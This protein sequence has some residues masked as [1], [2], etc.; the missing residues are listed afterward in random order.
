MKSDRIRKWT[1]LIYANGNNDLEPETWQAKLATEKYCES[2]EVNIVIQIGR[3]DSELV[4]IMRPNHVLSEGYGQWTGVRR[5]IRT[6][7]EW[8]LIKDLGKENMA[9]PYCLYE[10]VKDGMA[11]YPAEHYMV[12]M[13]GHGYQF[14]GSMP[15]YSQDVPYIMGFPG[16]ANALDKACSELGNNIDLLVADICYFNF[17]EVIYEF[18]KHAHHAVQN[19]L[20]YICD[21]PIE[22]MQYEK[23][24]DQVQNTA[25]DTGVRE[26][27]VGL[28]EGLNL[29]LVAVALDYKRLESL[30]WSFHKLACCYID[31]Q[32]NVNVSLNEILFATDSRYPW[33]ALAQEA[34]RALENLIIHYK[35]NSENDYG[36]LNIANTPTDN[37]KLNT[38][39][40]KLSFTQ[41]NAWS[42]LVTKQ[43]NG[44]LA[45]TTSAPENFHP[46]VLAPEEIYAYISIM[47]EDLPKERKLSLLQQL[48]AFKKWAWNR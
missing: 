15:D 10:F 43:K 35:R 12:I 28:V 9:S 33:C 11:S 32:E 2:D 23:I 22:G 40:A 41:N 45:S 5:Y 29:D 17:I 42:S 39:Y 25:A 21:G 46:I 1:I 20:T 14:V 16:M 24:I 4:K 6:N 31:N 38:F 8:L 3:V 44:T 27:I 19:V 7:G 37:L 36:L 47:N 13:G 18:G 30:K 34:L 48:Y 26:I